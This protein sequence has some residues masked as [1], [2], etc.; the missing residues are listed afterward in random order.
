MTSSPCASST[1]RSGNLAEV[2]DPY[3]GGDLMVCC[4]IVDSWFV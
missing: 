3:G 1:R 4:N 2:G